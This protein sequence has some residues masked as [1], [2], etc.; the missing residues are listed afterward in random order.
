[1]IFNIIEQNIPT[2]SE[3]LLDI[4][5]GF[6][7]LPMLGFLAVAYLRAAKAIALTHLVYGAL[8]AQTEEPSN[9]RDVN[10]ENAENAEPTSQD[11]VEK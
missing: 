10:A 1:M 3:L 9:A 6:R 7:S 2:S 4:T 11:E 8:E 5:H